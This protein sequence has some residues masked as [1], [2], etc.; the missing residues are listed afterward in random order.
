MTMQATPVVACEVQVEA[1]VAQLPGA[2]Q[3]RATRL[4][5]GRG[6]AEVTR[7]ASGPELLILW[8]AALTATEG[9]R[10]T[11]LVE[12]LSQLTKSVAAGRGW[13][14]LRIKS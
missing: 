11:G 8:R 5:C 1:I 12:R 9:V 14:W 4:R 7:G 10:L 6:G 13:R 2:I 3:T